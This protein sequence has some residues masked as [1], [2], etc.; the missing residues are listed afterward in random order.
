MEVDAPGSATDESL[1]QIVAAINTVSSF[2]AHE[3]IRDS[4]DL[5]RAFGPEV[6]AKQLETD[7]IVLCGSAVLSTAESVFSAVNE[8][9]NWRSM[10]H[11]GRR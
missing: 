2:L 3:Q 7:V 11:P 9:R 4:T 1:R 10:C 6:E 8:V 5:L